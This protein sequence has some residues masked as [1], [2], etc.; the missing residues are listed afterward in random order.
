MNVADGIGVLRAI[1]VLPISWAILTD[2]RPLAL[3]MFALAALSD[4]VDGWLARRFGAT[5]RHGT[6]LDPLADKVLTVGT[7]A[8]LSVA[9]TGWPVTVVAVLVGVRE[10]VVAALRIRGFSARAAVPADRLAKLKTGGELVGTAMIIWAVRP[11]AVLGVGLV[12]LAFL[13]GVY[14]LPRY[15]GTSRHTS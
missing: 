15:R 7:L 6:L 5:T 2:Q 4:A 13:L 14:T 10:L 3:A 11:W 1:A 9:G 12:G 8:A